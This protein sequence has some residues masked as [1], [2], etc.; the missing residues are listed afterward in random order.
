MPPDVQTSNY[1]S[2]L[3]KY[4]IRRR[5]AWQNLSEFAQRADRDIARHHRT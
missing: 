5:E 1:P 2:W 4:G 3:G